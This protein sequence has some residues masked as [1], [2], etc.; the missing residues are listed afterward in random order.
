MPQYNYRN[1]GVLLIKKDK[2]GTKNTTL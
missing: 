2:Y 1:T